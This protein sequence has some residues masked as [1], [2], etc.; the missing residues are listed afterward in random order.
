VSTVQKYCAVFLFITIDKTY[1]ILYKVYTLIDRL[2]GV[3]MY[4]LARSFGTFIL[5]FLVLYYPLNLSQYFKSDESKMGHPRYLQ[6]KSNCTEHMIEKGFC[7]ELCIEISDEK[8]SSADFCKTTRTSSLATQ[9]FGH[10]LVSSQCA[11]EA[12]KN[13]IDYTCPEYVKKHMTIAPEDIFEFCVKM[14]T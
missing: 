3:N 2:Q 7:K 4:I 11:L 10:S 1:I 14:C 8:Q 12:K 6:C 13:C 5:I 9:R